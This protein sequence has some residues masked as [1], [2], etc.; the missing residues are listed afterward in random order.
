MNSSTTN[1][2]P[3]SPL[4]IAAGLYSLAAW[5]LISLRTP[6]ASPAEAAG[7]GAALGVGKMGGIAANSSG[8]IF[9]A[10]S[11]ANPGAANRNFFS[12]SSSSNGD[13]SGDPTKTV[14]MLPNKGGAEPP[15]PGDDM[16]RGGSD[17]Q[18]NAC[19]R[20]NDGGG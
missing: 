11:T 6:F 17:R 10:F 2:F 19:R 15:V 8:E 13:W 5:P 14:V 7:Q 4:V 20:D 12:A 9:I 3:K 18:R 1:K 16:G